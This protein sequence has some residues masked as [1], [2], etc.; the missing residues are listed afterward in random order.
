VSTEN[1]IRA[2]RENA[3]HSTGPTSETG[4]AASCMNNFRHG[5]TGVFT[6]LPSEDQEEFDAL[7]RGLRAEH[8]P[9]TIT[10]TILVEKM[11]Q[12]LW[13]SQRAQRLQDFTMAAD[14]PIRDEERQFGSSCV[15]KLPMIE[16]SI[17]H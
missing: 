2:N 3:Q 8:K 15:I 1:Q 4:R 9:S 16:P 6:V 7:V 10:E 14:L 12:H 11:A 5:F 13:L 17:V